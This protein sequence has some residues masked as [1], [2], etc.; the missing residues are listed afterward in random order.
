MMRLVRVSLLTRVAM[1]LALVGLLPVGVLAYRLVGLNREAM[2]DQ[3][4]LAQTRAAATISSR[5]ETEVN[6]LL[7]VAESTAVS[8]ALADPRSAAARD[9]LRSNLEAWSHLDVVAIAVVN[10]SGEPV[11]TAQLPD[12]EIRERVGR[13]LE[14]GVGRP[15]AAVPRPAPGVPATDEE[16]IEPLLDLRVSFE[17]PDSRGFVWVVADGWRIREAV[18]DPEQIGGE[19][20]VTLAHRDGSAILGSVE[21]YP[22]EVLERAFNPWIEGVQPRFQSRDGPMLGGFRAVRNTDWAVLTRQKVEVA[23]AV[24]EAME[25]ES[26]WAVGLVS[27]S[28]ALLSGLAWASFVRPIRQL[29][30]AQRR[31]AG[32][33]GGSSGSEI[34]QLQSAFD[35]LEVRLKERSALDEV[36]LG[37]YQVREV[38]GSGAMGTVFLGHDPRLQRPVALKTIRLD[39]K[40]SPEKRRELL[41]RLIQ[42]AV[43]TAKFNHPNIVAVYDVEEGGN[44]AYM[45]MEYVDGVSLEAMVWR[46]E[47]LSAD[48]VV[49]LGGAVA[50]ALA[51]AHGNALVHRDVKPANILLGK[52]GSIKVTDFGISELLSSMRQEEDVVFGTP[53]YLPPETLQGKGYDAS[54]DLFSLG[55]VL[56]YCLSGVPPFE[57]KTVKD[58]I[59]KTLF[60]S[61]K[62]LSE[63]TPG[64]GRDLEALV[65]SLLSS[66]RDRRPA[67]ARL[68]ADRLAA[69]QRERGAIWQPDPALFD[70]PAD[71]H[72]S[73][74]TKFVPTT[75]LAP[76]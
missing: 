18:A 22:P 34:E 3:V 63:V 70:A 17:L 16:R 24:A 8:R 2:E 14:L 25:R 9:L 4:L 33:G 57:G 41:D 15:V 60:S 72:Q 10:P 44:A 11:L 62:P 47:R 46:R 64:I 48:E 53:G 21:P 45:A 1:A 56:Y 50:D 59:R 7:S 68:V 26:W 29:A 37:R 40:I 76:S 36:F 43:T 52:D 67:D 38:I 69:M 13:A 61:V 35:A 30:A 6:K 73:P 65:M 32:I 42:E 58:V 66:D 74:A 28:V 23:H 49:V 27:L 19:A 31:L 71:D 54:G 51:A 55:A 12:E 20:E 39:R 75:N 5:I